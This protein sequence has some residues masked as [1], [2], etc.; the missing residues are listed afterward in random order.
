MIARKMQFVTDSGDQSI[1]TQA[2]FDDRYQD[3]SDPLYPS[4]AILYGQILY[5]QGVKNQIGYIHF[6]RENFAGADAYILAV[7]GRA[8]EGAPFKNLFA[9]YRDENTS[10]TSDNDFTW[11]GE[12]IEAAIDGANRD[13]LL[14]LGFP[15]MP[16]MRIIISTYNDAAGGDL[17]LEFWMIS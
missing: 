12:D 7:Q 5:S 6:E 13:G 11:N 1:I 10:A 2:V 14:S 4:T 9:A 8:G 15:L 3:A 16:Q 17:S